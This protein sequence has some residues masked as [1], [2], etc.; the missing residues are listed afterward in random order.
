MVGLTTLTVGL[1]A[2]TANAHRTT[3]KV[4]AHGCKYRTIQKAVDAVHKGSKSTIQIEPGTYNEGVFLVGHKYDHL[5]IVGDTKNP[6]KV[7]LNGANAR[8]KAGSPAQNAVEAV[9]VDGLVLENMWGKNFA[10]NGF[11]IH[12]DPDDHCHGFLMKNMLAS[13]NRSYGF[14]AQNCTGGRITKTKGWGHGD[15]AIYIGQ[16]PVQNKP[17]WTSIDHNQGFENVL[18]YS[19]TNSKYV[20][21]HNNDFFNNGIGVV[22]NTLDSELYE[23]TANGK[24]RHN[25]IF[26]NNFDYWRESSKVMTVS[27]DLGQLAPNVDIQYPTGIGVY[28]LGADGWKITDND[29]F[30]N[31]KWGVAASSDPTN[32]G[33]NA[34]NQNNVYTGNTMGRGGKDKNQFDFFNDGSGSGNC[35]SDNHSQLFDDSG[36]GTH[37][38][39]VNYGSC[40]TGSGSGSSSGP[41]IGYL[42]GYVSSDDGDGS[43]PPCNQEN[44]WDKHSHP[45]FKN[46]KPLTTTGPCTNRPQLQSKAQKA[47]A[48]ATAKRATKKVGVYNDYYSPNSAN[49][50]KGGKVKWTWFGDDHNVTLDKAPRGVKKN[51]FRSPTAGAGFTFTRKFTKTGTYHFHCVVHPL[52]MQMTVKVTR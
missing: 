13:F 36:T 40:P 30:G 6:K 52:D 22:P 35:Y 43:N 26:W 33:D 48:A 5:Q 15:S 12:S 10:D 44:S 29:I 41:Q 42:I 49:V 38:D 31:F 11:F 34:I 2:G 45:K 21:I 28:M 39:P 19:G 16:T 24:I 1:M 7:V 37:T 32:T 8:T 20:D 4:C 51:D 50:A 27:S 47:A 25:N 3:F 18:G 17:K 23:P 14:F 46:Y 9:N